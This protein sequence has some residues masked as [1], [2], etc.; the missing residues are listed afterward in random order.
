[1]KKKDGR[2]IFEYLANGT[3]VEINAPNEK[4]IEEVICK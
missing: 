3:I 1:M 4:L 2:C